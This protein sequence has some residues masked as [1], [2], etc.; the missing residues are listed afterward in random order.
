MRA[1]LPRKALLGIAATVLA[2]GCSEVRGR[3]LVQ[4]GNSLYSD[5]LY[6][7]AVAVFEQAEKFVPDLPELWLNK[8][9]TCRQIL[10][11]GS[12][13]PESIA[14]AKC[15]KEAFQRYQKLR[16]ADTRGEMLYVQTLFDS[17]EF[18]TLAKMYEARFQK[19]PKDLEAVNGL[20]Q[21]YT[22]A[23]DLDLALEWYARKADLMSNDAQAQYGAG[24][25]IYN[26][27]FQ[28]GG[29]PEKSMH[30]PRPDPNKPGEVKSHP[31]WAPGDI[32][33]QQ[34]VDLADSGIKYLQRALQI[35]PKY[36]EAMT[37]TNLLYRQKSFAYFEYPQE[38]QKSVDEAT[39]WL[40]KSLDTQGQKVPEN[41]QK[42][43]AAIEAARASKAAGE[44]EGAEADKAP[45]GKRGKGKRRGKGRKQARGKAKGKRA[46]R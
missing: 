38:W 44:A 5:G 2:A 6:K 29:A 8:G 35:N 15:A 21:V 45:K 30:D 26:Q 40:K 18:D 27:L 24:V 3:R 14:A 42:M 16:P 46:K 33:S 12:D 37:Y 20:I 32:V 36:H 39:L 13:K 11:P 19:N 31:G 4:E 10:I 43:V 7:E 23:N 41:V 34:R 1:R 17:D 28:R 22:K 9:Y 25:F